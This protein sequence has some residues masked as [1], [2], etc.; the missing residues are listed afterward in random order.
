MSFKVLLILL[1]THCM[2]I[3]IGCGYMHKVLGLIGLCSFLIAMFMIAEK[4]GLED[5][6][7]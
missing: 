4:G 5:D 2:V 6:H 7:I 3:L 1:F